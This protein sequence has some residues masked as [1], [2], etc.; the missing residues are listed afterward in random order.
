M[1]EGIAFR[2]RSLMEALAGIGLAQ[3]GQIVASGGFTQS[4]LWMQVVADGLNRELNAPVWGET[5]C[6]GAAFWAMLGTGHLKRIEEVRDLVRMGES[7]HP[8]PANV[9]VYDRIYPL[10]T[11][12]YHSLSGAFEEVAGL[13]RDLRKR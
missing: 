1:L 5:S 8:D 2:I 7:L 6:L 10:Y 12:I 9:A 4:R 3:I 11:R 13:Q